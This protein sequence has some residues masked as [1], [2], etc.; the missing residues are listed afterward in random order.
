M[1]ATSVS[2]CRDCCKREVEFLGHVTHVTG[3]ITRF[4]AGSLVRAHDRQTECR[5]KNRFETANEPVEAGFSLLILLFLERTDVHPQILY[6][7]THIIGFQFWKQSA[8]RTILCLSLIDCLTHVECFRFS[9]AANIVEAPKLQTTSSVQAST[10]AS[11]SSILRKRSRIL[12]HDM[13]HT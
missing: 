9:L 5:K 13:S 8:V 3:E 6:V 4:A 2:T 1:V 7:S 10:T 11:V 12:G